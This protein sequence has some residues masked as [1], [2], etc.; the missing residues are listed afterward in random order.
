MQLQPNLRKAAELGVLLATLT[1]VLLA[2]CGGGSGAG[3][4]DNTIGNATT[5][6]IVPSLG[7]FNAGT[8]VQVK[9]SSGVLIGSGLVTDRGVATIVVPSSAQAPLLVEVGLNGDQFFDEKQ[10]QFVSIS[11]VNNVAIRSVVP[12]YTITSQVAVTALTEMSV[13]I[14]TNALGALPAAIDPADAAAANEVIELTFD[15]NNLLYPPT[16]VGSNLEALSL[17]GSEADVYAAKLA[18]LAQLAGANENALTLTHRLRDTVIRSV[19]AGSMNVAVSAFNT[20]MNA[21]P[22]VPPSLNSSAQ[23]PSLA[24][25]TSVNL[26]NLVALAGKNAQSAKAK[27]FALKSQPTQAEVMQAYLTAMSQFSSTIKPA[28][29][30][31]A[32]ILVSTAIARD[33]TDS[34]LNGR[35]QTQPGTSDSNSGS[36]A[37][38]CT[39]T[40]VV[41]QP[42]KV[43]SICI[44]FVG[45][46]YTRAD[47]SCVDAITN[48]TGPI[49]YS[50]SSGHCSAAAAY[51][52]CAIDPGPLSLDYFFM[53]SFGLASASACTG[54]GGIW[55]ALSGTNGGSTPSTPPVVAPTVSGFSPTSGATGT[56]VTLTGTNFDNT[57]GNNTVSFN[58]MQ[59]TVTSATSTSITATV[60]SGATSGTISIQTAGGIVTSA[61][62]FSVLPTLFATTG[63]AHSN[64][65]VME[66]LK[67]PFV[68]VTFAYNHS[69]DGNQGDVLLR[70]AG[71][72]QWRFEND[73]SVSVDDTASGSFLPYAYEATTDSSSYLV[74]ATGTYFR[75]YRT[76]S[77]GKYAEWISGRGDIRLVDPSSSIEMV[78]VGQANYNLT[79]AARFPMPD[80]R[81][82]WAS[83]SYSGTADAEWNIDHTFYTTYHGKPCVATID[84][85][86]NVAM[87]INGIALPLFHTYDT[88]WN[89]GIPAT[90]SAFNGAAPDTMF[91]ANPL[92]N[93]DSFFALETGRYSNSPQTSKRFFF[94]IYF[95]PVKF[96]DFSRPSLVGGDALLCTVQ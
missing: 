35:Y 34:I 50:S 39:A 73:G 16:L 59:A 88:L 25:G 17:G 72:C 13:G 48:T 62:N 28:L 46:G 30:S 75:F 18:G 42:D 54:M 57:P 36:T 43:L 70:S 8:H 7:K 1:T 49:S 10:G 92:L 74:R 80:G 52:K 24:P 11:G 67:G 45:S 20:A 91:S 33:K 47:V 23:I 38:S 82:A 32:N 68:G 87:T 60:P 58:G 71:P 77:G 85:L 2:G 79:A 64:A 3:S 5:L 4:P 15:V 94:K 55:T 37:G 6:S 21:T 89:F 53:D 90:N 69:S 44:D 61:G 41:T 81:L 78:C 27:L 65:G 93:P 26:I 12:D 84:A 19:S 56:T 40:N 14:L 51:G 96:A 63:V 31:G 22:G 66:H 29:T 83:G 86:G 76:A 9:D 95:P